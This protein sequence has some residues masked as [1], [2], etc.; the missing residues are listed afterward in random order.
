MALWAPRFLWTAAFLVAVSVLAPPAGVSAAPSPSV[1]SATPKRWVQFDLIGADTDEVVSVGKGFEL[2]VVLGGVPSG[3]DPVVAVFDTPWFKRRVVPMTP[4]SLPM[5]LRGSVV[6]EPHPLGATSVPPKAAR[7]HVTFARFRNMKLD[8]IMTRIVYVTLGQSEAAAQRNATATV[9]TAATAEEEKDAADASQNASQDDAQLEVQPDV[10]P[11][12]NALISEED[13]LP[14]PMP[15]KGNAYWQEVSRLI[16]RSWSHR[17][18][19]QRQIPTQETV[20]VRFRMY[21]SGHAQLI[22]IERGSGVR[23]IDEAGIQAIVQAEP[24]PPFPEEL[25]AEA[26]DVHV[27]MRTGLHSVVKNIHSPQ[28][29]RNG[30][31]TVTPQLKP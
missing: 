14:L 20:R 12:A 13:L 25:G 2:A 19:Y 26:V 7:I 23:E 22:E 29:R 17:M 31:A 6:L 5:T 10:K 15:A 24:F 18:R 3:S 30:S 16:S 27:R 21:P 9:A 4:D 1:P 11:M 8:R 28:S